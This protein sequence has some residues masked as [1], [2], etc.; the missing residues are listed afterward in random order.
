MC[1][2]IKPISISL[3]P[4]TEPDDNL[5]ALKLQ[6]QP[7]LWQRG[8]AEK[9]AEEEFRKYLGV[10][11]AISFNSARSALMAI[12]WALKLNKND[13]VFLQAFTCN[14]AVNPIIWSGLK[15]VFIDCDE[16]SYNIDIDKI[17]IAPGDKPKAL[18]VQHTFGLPA[19]IDKAIEFCK[20]N[21]LVLIEDCAHA[22]GAEFTGRKVGNFGDAAFFSFSRDKIISSV[23]GGMAVTNNDELAFKIRGFQAQIG[24][25]SAGWVFQQLLHPTTMSWLILPTYKIFGKYLLVFLQWIHILSKAVNWKE[26]RGMKPVYF[27]KRMPNAL[28]LLFLNQLKKVD[29]FNNHRKKIADFYL[30]RLQEFKDF[31]VSPAPE[32]QKKKNVFLRFAVKH[33]KA[34]EIIKKAWQ[35]NILI[36]DWYDS[37]IAPK[38]TKLDKLG[39]Q[40]GTCPNAEKLATE[41]FNLPTHINFSQ[42]EAQKVIDFLKQW[43][44]ER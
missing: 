10:K 35:K 23:Y 29:R 25:P 38:D 28:S 43:R 42:K 37:P 24:Y 39:Y 31:I 12:L 18:M 13:G 34:H 20:K 4:N 21:G 3:S 8:G 5:L 14:A 7:W 44:L 26:K 22:L 30:A 40:N 1:Q 33:Q 6:F 16:V 17:E 27:P 32:F 19:D 9:K 15:P 36:G 41:T 11:H 2:T